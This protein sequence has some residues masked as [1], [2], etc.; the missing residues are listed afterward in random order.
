MK[1]LA[2]K[3]SSSDEPR[4]K[5]VFLRISAHLIKFS[6][7]RPICH[8]RSLLRHEGLSSPKDKG[9]RIRGRARARA[10]DE[11]IKEIF[12][13]ESARGR[14]VSTLTGNLRERVLIDCQGI[15]K[16]RLPRILV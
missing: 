8:E 10:P 15:Q 3:W 5:V 6:L 16:A 4:I 1:S 9:I 14:G 13:A 11:T 7:F 12:G 2:Y